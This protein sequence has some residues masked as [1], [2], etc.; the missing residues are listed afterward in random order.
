M[1]LLSGPTGVGKTELALG[2]ARWLSHTRARPG[3]AFYTSFD[4]GAGVERVV[5][6][7]GTTIAG[8]EF[9]DMPAQQQRDW[10]V[11]YLGEHPS[12]L[13][14][15]RL[16]NVAGFPAAGSGLLDESEQAQLDD[17]LGDVAKGWPSLGPTG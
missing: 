8:L 13:I 2:L 5:H 4:V 9:A 17:F 1:V 16:E 15:D 12:L 3:G 10:L 11:E 6:E 7:V 14:L